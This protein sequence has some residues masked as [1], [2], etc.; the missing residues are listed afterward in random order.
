VLCDREA[1]LQA[2]RLPRYR[3]RPP[4]NSQG[5]KVMAYWLFQSN[6]KYSKNLSKINGVS[7]QQAD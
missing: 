3:H 1:L 4:P 5:K 6:P 2:V 7:S